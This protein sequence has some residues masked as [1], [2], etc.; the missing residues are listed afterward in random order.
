MYVDEPS[1]CRWDKNDLDFGSMGNFFV[2]DEQDLDEFNNYECDTLLTGLEN[3]DNNFYFRCKDNNNNTN[4][5]SYQ[6]VLKGTQT[7]L[8]ISSALPTGTIFTQDTALQ[9]TTS[10][11]AENGKATCAFS[12]NNITYADFFTT[13]GT[14]HTQQLEDLQLGTYRY[15]VNCRDKAGNEAN[16]EINFAVN[17]DKLAPK[18]KYIYKDTNSV[19]VVLDEPAVCEYLEKSFS[20]GSGIKTGSQLSAEHT[21]PLSGKE[22]YIICEDKDKNKSP[23]VKIVL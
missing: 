7:Q 2:C 11:G 15:F 8:K 22:A 18:I 23:I 9:A 6:F 5:Q 13:E 14:I 4:A 20:Y 17:V 21:I 1:A 12:S 3:K 19:H 10:G 16:G